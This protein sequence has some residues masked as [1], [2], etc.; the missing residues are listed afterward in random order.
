[1]FSSL[2]NWVIWLPIIGGI[3]VLAIG[4]E[5][6]APLARKIS[7]AVAVLTFLISIPLYTGFDTSTA[8]MQSMLT[9]RWPSR[10]CS[11]TRKRLALRSS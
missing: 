8:A 3:A 10:S 9:T 11:P 2:L 6:R 7:L 1:M 5:E 4:S